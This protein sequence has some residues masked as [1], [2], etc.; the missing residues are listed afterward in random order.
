VAD[1]YCTGA[2]LNTKNVLATIVTELKR[3]AEGE[4]ARL[5]YIIRIAEIDKQNLKQKV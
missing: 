5:S 4:V 1:F 2:M 3:P